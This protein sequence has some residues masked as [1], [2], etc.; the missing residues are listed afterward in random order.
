M[1]Y[2][3]HA[4]IYTPDSTIEAGAVLVD[5]ARIAAVGAAA[6]LP[7][8]AGAELLD[9][10]GGIVAPGF[11]DLQLNGAFGDDFTVAPETIW[12]VA[13]GLPRWGVTAF[14]PTIITAPLAQAGKAQEV[15][16]GGPPP[17]WQGSIPLGLHCEGSLSQPAEKGR[18]Q[19]SAS[20]PAFI[21][22]R[23]RLVAADA[24][25]AGDAGP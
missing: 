5:G 16:A 24:C 8:P 15:L 23:G 10:G 11:I 6:D 14:L 22:G 1:L 17:G 13:A 25:A 19:P 7:A 9:A 21:R 12:R 18:T 4:T 20:A 3:H 2:I